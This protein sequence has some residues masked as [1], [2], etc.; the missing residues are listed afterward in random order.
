MIFAANHRGFLDPFI[1]G[2]DVAASRRYYV[3]QESCS[4]RGCRRGSST[5]SVRGGA[6]PCSTGARRA[7]W[8][9]GRRSMAW[10]LGPRRAAPR[11]RRDLRRAA[12]DDPGA[13][14]RAP[15]PCSRGWPD[16]RRLEV[17]TRAWLLPFGLRAHGVE[18]P[19]LTHLCP[20]SLTRGARQRGA[21]SNRQGDGIHEPFLVKRYEAVSALASFPGAGAQAPMAWSVKGVRRAPPAISIE[22]LRCCRSTLWAASYDQGDEQ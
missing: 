22:A 3:A 1:I 21:P 9:G 20:D 11:S 6:R 8:D 18:N 2:T 13:S 12:A 17:R 14:I 19:P 4:P 7:A 16:L 10:A 15:P 5:R